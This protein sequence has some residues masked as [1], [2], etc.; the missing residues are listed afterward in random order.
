MFI[1]GSVD[2]PQ[3]LCNTCTAQSTVATAELCL[4]R[5]G[6]ERVSP[7]SVQQISECSDG[8]GLDIGSQLERVNTHC[9]TGF[10]D[11]HFSFLVNGLDGQ[12]DSAINNPEM[13]G[14]ETC[15]Q[16]SDLT[17]AR[18]TD[19]VADIFT[20]EDH[21]MDAVT[22]VGA[23]ATNIAVTANLVFYGGGLYYNPEE[24]V[25]YVEEPVP[26]QC[27]AAFSTLIGPG[28]IRLGSHWSR[29]LLAPA[30]LCHKESARMQNTWF[31]MA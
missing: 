8:T 13:N 19:Y 2:V 26:V 18:V 23:R 3:Q 22:M 4:C 7:R 24:C 21:L 15:S 10:P 25:D 20:T 29:V 27:Q 6:G 31:F 11:V 12:L 30:I 5:A 14:T 28:Q 17:R 16:A 1:V 9:V